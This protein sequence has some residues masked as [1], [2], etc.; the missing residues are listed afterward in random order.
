MAG[1]KLSVRTQELVRNRP[2]PMT[3]AKME[4]E[5]AGRDGSITAAWLFSFSA[6]RLHCVDC[7]KVQLVYEYM[8]GVALD[9][10]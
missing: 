10:D 7:D 1:V 5:L 8:T 4:S 2:K 9:I 6:G 3:F